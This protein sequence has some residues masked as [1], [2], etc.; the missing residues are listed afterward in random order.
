MSVLIRCTITKLTGAASLTA[1]DWLGLKRRENGGEMKERRKRTEAI[2][3]RNHWQPGKVV[4]AN[5]K[6][7]SNIVLNYGLHRAAALPVCTRLNYNNNVTDG[8]T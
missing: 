1:G 2:I 4:V 3:E 5:S 7:V 6:R 8:Y